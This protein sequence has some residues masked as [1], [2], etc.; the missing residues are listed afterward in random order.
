[1]AIEVIEVIGTRPKP[2]FDPRFAGSGNPLGQRVD[3]PGEIGYGREQGERPNAYLD[4]EITVIG[5]QLDPDVQW[6]IEQGFWGNLLFSWEDFF[7]EIPESQRSAADAAIRDRDAAKLKRAYFAPSPGFMHPGIEEIVVRARMPETKRL[8]LLKMALRVRYLAGLGLLLESPGLNVGE[9]EE[10]RRS[11]RERILEAGW[12]LLEDGSIKFNPD[13]PTVLRWPML[14]GT[15]EDFPE[16]LSVNEDTFPG[17][18]VRRLRTRIGDETVE[19]L[20]HAEDGL[21]TERE[22]AIQPQV[23]P[24]YRYGWTSVEEAEI[25]S[26]LARWMAQQ[27]RSVARVIDPAIERQVNMPIWIRDVE[28]MVPGVEAI[29]QVT[30]GVS[31][32]P[33]MQL[34]YKFQ[35]QT[36]FQSRQTLR[37]QT[38]EA[39]RPRRDAKNR[40]MVGYLAAMRF[41]TKTWGEVSEWIDRANALQDNTTWTRSMYLT[42]GTGKLYVARGSSLRI[43]PIEWKLAALKAIRDDPASIS[44]DVTGFLVDMLIMEVSD[45]SIAMVG[46]L[47][48]RTLRAHLPEGHP[49]RNMFGNPTSWAERMKTWKP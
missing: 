48:E 8:G 44:L 24:K 27:G 1:M 41:V 25:A 15:R 20:E 36:R 28:G 23:K 35:T 46:Q 42:N 3:L 14:A 5:D 18:K 9:E 37:Q 43:V 33:A 21:W 10:L 4:E 38:K 12:R 22:I 11:A 19:V 30:I 7:A 31:V 47:E 2:G 45:R 16:W 39:R 26:D 34:K 6:L 49:L 13:I 29:P 17:E 40:K 32:G